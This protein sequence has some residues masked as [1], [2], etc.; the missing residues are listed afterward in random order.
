MT[1]SSSYTPFL[2]GEGQSKTGLFSYLDSWVKPEDAFDKMENAFVYRSSL[3]ERQGMVLFPSIRGAGSLVYQDDIQAAV[4]NGTTG[5]FSGTLSHVPLFGTVTITAQTAAGKRSSTASF[6]A[7]T[8]AWSTGGTSLATVVAGEGIDFTTGVW[9]ITTSSAVVNNTPIMIQYSYVPNRLATPI[10]NPIMGIDTFKNEINN[11][12]TIVVTDTRRLNYYDASTPEFKPVQT[13]SDLIF[14]GNGVAVTTPSVNLQ[15][16]SPTSALAP[17]SLTAQIIDTSGAVVDTSHDVPDSLTHGTWSL[18][19]PGGIIVAGGSVDYVTGAVTV[20]FGATMLAA[21]F[22]VRITGN[23]TGDYF[24]GNNTNFFNF[25]NWRPSD[26][27]LSNLWMVNN[28]DP[29]TLFTLV[30]GTVP[31]LSRPALG[32]TVDHVV[33]FFNDIATALDLQVYKESMLLIRPTLVGHNGPEPQSIFWNRPFSPLTAQNPVYTPYDFAQDIRGHGGFIN[34]STGDWI[35]N[36]EPLRDVLVVS[37]TNTTFLFRYTGNESQPFVFIQVNNSRSTNAPYGGVSYDQR[38]TTM[39]SKGLIFCDGNNVDRY[40]IKAIDL[41][42]DINQDHFEQCYAKKFD[43]LNQTWMLYPSMNTNESTSDSVLVYNYLEDTWAKFIPNLGQLVQTPTSPNTL[44]VTGLGFTT[45][46]LTWADFG[47]NGTYPNYTWAMFD[48]AWNDNLEQ[49]L[50]PLLMGGDQN[51]FVYELNVG[52]FDNA[53]PDQ[54][55]PIKT[56]VITKQYNPFVAEGEKVRCG[57]LDVYYEVE[58]SIQLRF[59][60]YV[61]SIEG[62]PAVSRLITL[63]SPSPTMKT[64]WKRIFINL[65]GQF[66]QWEISTLISDNASPPVYN[67]NATFKILG[68]ILYAAPAGRLTPGTFT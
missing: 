1:G 46:D 7:G 60:F 32:I 53:G 35:M 3:Y 27:F 52:P 40:D 51:G 44:S 37:C 67:M 23:L 4:G 17:L 64:G 36:V 59:N 11:A 56:S 62:T 45:K 2:I 48:E 42:T 55:L 47:P 63:D 12:N 26:N 68:Q 13:F 57:Y 8:V 43:T 54:K 10:N 24:T 58:P 30:G 21:G 25:V 41:W 34:A 20:D 66:I 33:T 18:G 29:V 38:I 28:K 15:W 22:T 49:A 50:S 6:G 9:K 31:E 5:P 16:G 14:T 65:T 39:G 19:T 61:N